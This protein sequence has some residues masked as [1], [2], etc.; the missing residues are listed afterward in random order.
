[1]SLSSNPFDHDRARGCMAGLALGDALGR[2]VE[3]L[4]AAEI[5][6]Q[7]GY[8]EGFID[9]EPAGSDDTEYA[10]LSASTVL[11]VGT[12]ATMHDFAQSWID[13]VLPQSSEFAGGGFSE[14]AA[15]DNLRKGVAPPQSG[16]HIHAWSDGLAMRVAPLGIV[17]N[18]DVAMAARLAEADGAVSHSGEGI[19][20]GVAV[21]VA[22]TAAMQ[23][24][25]SEQCFEEALASIPSDS[26]TARNLQLA[27]RL[28][29]EESDSARL[30]VLLCDNLAISDYFWADLATEAVGL[31][32]GAL[33]HGG[34]D[35]VHTTTFAVNLGRD[36][37]TNAAIAGCIAG[38]I[39]GESS[40]PVDWLAVVQPVKGSCIRT[41]AGLHPLHIAD[42]L[43]ALIEGASA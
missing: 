36:S 13:N 28:V 34:G 14:M 8:I 22:V 11:R 21:A 43:G 29:H 39:S 17:A 25:S 3:G 40:I 2:P 26:W 31:A 10:L 38:A 7:W 5:Q 9:D 6:E 16:D 33:L 18:G 35:V 1:M 30:A 20:A 24:A 4:S 42:Q 12:G 27:Q 41:M 23:G 19:Y 32:F 37:D 15:I